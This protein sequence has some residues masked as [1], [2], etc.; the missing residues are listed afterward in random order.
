MHVGGVMNLDSMSM[1][2]TIDAM[3]TNPSLLKE[4]ADPHRGSVKTG[5][6]ESVALKLSG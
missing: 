3:I 6:L 4:K 5:F 2:L 1:R